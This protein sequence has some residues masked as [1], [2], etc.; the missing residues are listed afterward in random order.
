MEIPSLSEQTLCSWGWGPRRPSLQDSH[1]LRPSPW[2]RGRLLATGAHVPSPRKTSNS[3]VEPEMWGLCN[4]LGVNFPRGDEEL[5]LLWF[6][7]QSEGALSKGCPSVAIK[8]TSGSLS[9][10][11]QQRSRTEEVQTKGGVCRGRAL[12]EL[13]LDRTARPK[14]TGQGQG[15]RTCRSWREEPGKGKGAAH[16]GKPRQQSVALSPGGR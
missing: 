10:E 13:L 8:V 2:V 14:P 12:R 5:H 9:M 4:W 11:P 15:R 1:A 3:Q 7:E 16:G 6:P